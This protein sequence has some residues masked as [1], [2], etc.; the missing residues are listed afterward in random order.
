[1]EKRRRDFT[2]GRHC[3]RQALARLG[4]EPSPILRGASREPVW[5]PGVCGSITHCEGYCAAVVAL[6]SAI[7][8]IGVD[9][10][11]LRPLSD[12][13]LERIASETER[14]W[15]EAAG[16]SSVPWSLL[17]FSAKESVFK[18][19]F[20]VMGTWLGFEEARIEFQPSAGRFR[21]VIL[22]HEKNRDPDAPAEF[23]GRFCV[24]SER[25]VTSAFLPDGPRTGL[26]I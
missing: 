5:P 6:R 9:A 24:S 20:Q 3:A 13:V 25:V 14:C 11:S 4:F 1:V 7:P 21:A 17:L 8:T 19:W 22:P 12:G 23:I 26:L 10:E 15:I 16:P 2:M 18:A